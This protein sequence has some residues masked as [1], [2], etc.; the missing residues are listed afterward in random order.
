MAE[1]HPDVSIRSKLTAVTLITCIVALTLAALSVIVFELV[2]ARQD[3]ERHLGSLAAVVASRAGASTSG[4]PGDRELAVRA[5]EPLRLDPDVGAARISATDGTVLAD[6]RRDATV[7]PAEATTAAITNL[8]GAVVVS[9][10]VEANGAPVGTLRLQ[11]SL[12]AVRTRVR[13]YGWI[14]SGV[15]LVSILLAYVISRALTERIS[16]PIARLTAVADRVSRSRDYGARAV[17]ESDDEIG[18]LVERFNEM[19]TQIERRT[20][21]LQQARAEL[22]ARVRERTA[23]LEHEVEE[24]RR[25]EESLALAKAA[26][27]E[28]SLAKS[29][30]L[31]NMS[32]ELRTPLNAIIGY[33]EML[34]E[35]ASAQGA[36]E[37]LSD[38]QKVTTAGRQL[39]ALVTGVLDLSKIE[40]G[41]MELHVEAF[42]GV[43]LLKAVIDTAEP[44]A[45][46][47][48]NR[49]DIAGMDALGILQTDPVKLQQILLNL[50]G[51]ACKFT[52]HGR[53]DVE[54]SR[55]PRPEGDWLQVVVRDTGIGMTPEQMSRLFR[56]FSQADVSTTRRF[57]GTGLGLAISQRL[58]QLMGGRITVESEFGRGS[59]FTMRVPAELPL[60]ITDAPGSFRAADHGPAPVIIGPATILVVDDD[61]AH[62]EL[63]ARLLARAGCRVLTAETAGAGLELARTSEPDAI[64]LDLVLPD[65]S[66][67]SVLETLKADPALRAV[68]VVISSILDDRTRSLAGGAED[69]LLK[70]VD[71]ERLVSVL[72]SALARRR[73]VEPPLAA[74]GRAGTTAW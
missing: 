19:L 18:T 53:I 47:R 7:V 9:Q 46:D 55:L 14:M 51:N 27:E 49:L 42:A 1:L 11:G 39:L 31:A 70:P 65:D 26:A 4:G 59:T 58:C 36:T 2:N 73:T 72:Q 45:R 69:H 3:L 10:V 25:A 21:D 5:L 63:T 40:A 68:P 13:T 33:S 43:N 12:D 44:L 23:T 24:R 52:S 28:A 48:H 30:F 61:A 71:A 54:A 74:A 16:G 29:A 32:H 15:L 20:G 62:R 56:E 67:W 37:C 6:Y 57:G 8:D 35:D 22:E 41:R 34:Q 17:K 50:V 64:V 66:G 38:L 60:T